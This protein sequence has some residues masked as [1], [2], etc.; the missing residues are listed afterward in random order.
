ML[1]QFPP[2]GAAID[3]KKSGQL[4]AASVDADQLLEDRL[5]RLPDD[6]LQIGWLSSLLLAPH[7]QAL[8]EQLERGSGLLLRFP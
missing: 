7:R 4:L 5:F 6:R 1:L 8:I 3:A 2:Q